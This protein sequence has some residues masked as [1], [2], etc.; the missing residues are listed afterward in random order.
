MKKA[1]VTNWKYRDVMY[2]ELK[3]LAIDGWPISSN[4]L[5]IENVT[6]EQVPVIE[7]IA[8]KYNATVAWEEIA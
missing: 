1:L 5:E 2:A 8:K 4:E 6:D 7:A 3:D